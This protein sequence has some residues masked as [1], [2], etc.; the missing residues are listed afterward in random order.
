MLKA[1]LLN[2]QNGEHMTTAELKK[3]RDDEDAAA[4]EWAQKHPNLVAF[5]FLGIFCGL[6]ILAIVMMIWLGWYQGGYVNSVDNMG[7]DDNGVCHSPCGSR[8]HL[9]Y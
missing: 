7:Y 1:E 8:D 3:Q 4:E 9:S 2:Q 6:P 5:S